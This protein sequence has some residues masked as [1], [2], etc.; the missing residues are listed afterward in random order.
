M[1]GSHALLRTIKEETSVVSVDG[2]KY[3]VVISTHDV[4]T[5]SGDVLGIK[6]MNQDGAMDASI[7]QKGVDSYRIIDALAY[8]ATQMIAPNLHRV[9]IIGFYLLSDGLDDRGPKAI[10]AKAR[11]YSMGA[12]KIHKSCKHELPL[13]EQMKLEDAF[14]WVMTKSDIRQTTLF[15]EI[16]KEFAN[17]IEVL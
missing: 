15:K 4:P 17:Q 8:R 14:G 16:Q 10:R 7:R 11:L 3:T 9:A 5:L 6:F 1:M 12:R 2:F 13:I